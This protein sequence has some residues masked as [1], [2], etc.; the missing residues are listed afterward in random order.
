MSDDANQYWNAWSAAFGDCGLLPTKLLCE[1]HVKKNWRL[2]ITSKVPAT[3]RK[4]VQRRLDELIEA[5]EERKFSILL[6]K[7]FKDIRMWVGC[8]EFRKY[9]KQHYCASPF[10]IREWSL[11]A[12]RESEA[13]TNM[14]VETFHDKL[15]HVH[16]GG[17]QNRRAD[18]LIETLLDVANGYY[19]DYEII[20]ESGLPANTHRMQEMHK[21][22]KNSLNLAKDRVKYVDGG[23]LVPSEKETGRFYYVCKLSTDCNCLLK[24]RWC[25]VCSH[26]F[27][28]TCA[29]AVMPT[30]A[31]KHSHLIQEIYGGVS[32]ASSITSAASSTTSATSSITSAASSITTFDADVVDQELNSD[33]PM[34]HSDNESGADV[35]VDSHL[36][37]SSTG[38]LLGDVL[39]GLKDLDETIMLDETTSVAIFQKIREIKTLL[40][41]SSRGSAVPIV[42]DD[43]GPANKK[44]KRQRRF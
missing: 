14:F 9:L 24:C 18:C 27:S 37:N 1:W 29:D 23:W 32:T 43:A 16:F 31:C 12:R 21:R 4:E 19:Q 39:K 28:C 41:L 44:V 20:K 8:D 40:K 15:K 38:V 33:S 11:W 5:E 36:K 3:Y 25:R 13:N 35:V 10:R 7:F 6:T 2:N 42:S 22:H 26:A 30:T 17:K 34:A